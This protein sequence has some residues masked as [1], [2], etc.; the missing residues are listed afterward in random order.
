[1]VKMAMGQ[2]QFYFSYVQAPVEGH[3]V[4]TAV[5]GAISTVARNGNTL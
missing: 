5:R 1:V 3:C 2:V 4:L